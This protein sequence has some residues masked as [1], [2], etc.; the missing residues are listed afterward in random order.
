MAALPLCN[1]IKFIAVHFF[2][3]I[4]HCV[5]IFY[6]I[7]RLVYFNSIKL[8]ANWSPKARLWLDGRKDWQNE[9]QKKW[10]LK[11]FE[12]AV[13]MHCASL[14]EFEQGRPLL[15]QLKKENTHIKILVTFFSPSGY[16]IRK[17]YEGADFVMYLPADSNKNAKTFLNLANPALAIFVKYEF[18]H[19]YLA[20]LK[21]RK[22]ETILVSGIFRNTQPFFQWWG[23]FYKNMLLNFSHLFVQ[24]Q[25]SA[26]LLSSINITSNVTVCGDTR[27]DRVVTNA[28]QWKPIPAIETFIQPDKKIL[29][30]GSTWKEDEELIAQWW[31]QNNNEWQL[32]IAPHEI[33]EQHIEH[34]QKL[35]ADAVRFSTYKNQP[36]MVMIVD[37]IGHL[38]KIYRYATVSCIGGGLTKN[39]VH[40]TA[41]AAVY[42]KPVL[43]GPVYEKY[44]EAVD[45][46]HLKAAF[47][48]ANKEEFAAIIQHLSNENVYASSATAAKKYVLEN[49]GA[50][51]IIINY[52][53][54]KRLFTS[55]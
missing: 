46:I 10:Q 53:Q 43:F 50:A 34:L 27:F 21:Q 49:S 17:N 3:F 28:Q 41:E 32:I 24:D 20:E 52:I 12:K 54:E 30:A 44:K 6:N 38:S 51:Q 16:E 22:I 2:A 45:L 26:A 35:F 36:A 29:V 14:G 1:I 19:F 9:F 39:G 8:A 15:E 55:A 13:W 47:S 18:W 5:I 25:A 37:T 11:P 31:M 42:G 7:F 40:N 33:D 4:L 48:F 23:S